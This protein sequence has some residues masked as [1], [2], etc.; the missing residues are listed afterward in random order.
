[1]ELRDREEAEEHAED[2]RTEDS[3]RFSREV[4]IHGENARRAFPSTPSAVESGDL[5][6]K[7]RGHVLRQ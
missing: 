5:R 1:M 3:H 4:Q 6:K 2:R 7:R